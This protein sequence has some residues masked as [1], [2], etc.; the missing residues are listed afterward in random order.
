MATFSKR[1][2]KWQA[3]VFVDGKQKSKGGFSTKGEAKIW[4]TEIESLRNNGELKLTEKFILLSDYF[5]EWVNTYKVDITPQ[6]K[7]GYDNTLKFI[8][9]NFP[10]VSLKQLTREK[11][12]KSFNLYGKTH[13]RETARKRRVHLKA[14]LQDAVIDGIVKSNPFERI[15][16]TGLESKSASM[17]FLES[18]DF[19]NLIAYVKDNYSKTHDLILT[20]TMTGARIGELLALTD[21]DISNGVISINKAMDPRFHQIKSTKTESSNRNVDVPEWLTYRL[22]QY[23]GRLW[24]ITE[25]GAN[26]SLRAALTKINAE[27]MITFHGLRHSH[28]SYLIAHDVAIEYISERLG[29]ANIAITQEVYSHLLSV[30]KEK[31]VKKT[32]DILV[33]K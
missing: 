28:A 30:K 22:K 32:L 9:S 21:Q 24:G 29:H 1:G 14:A 13:T 5:S 8:E 2:K 4:A 25:A 3:R 18:K 17:K 26:K 12:Q 11:A 6:T 20:G 16:L 33:Q 7:M 31:E 19:E 15:I 10:G 27:K 23:K